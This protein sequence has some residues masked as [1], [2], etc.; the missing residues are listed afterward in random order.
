[1][2][3]REILHVG[4]GST[5]CH[6][7]AHYLNLQ[8]LSVTSSQHPTDE[9]AAEA[10]SCEA[11]ITH[12]TFQRTIVP[13]TLLVD[14]APAIPYRS[15]DNQPTATTSSSSAAI[16]ASK[17]SFLNYSLHPISRN[18]SQ[19]FQSAALWHGSIERLDRTNDVLMAASRVPNRDLLLEAR[20]TAQQLSWAS[21]S[22]YRAP[23][24]SHSSPEYA[25]SSTGRTVDWDSLP[26]EGEEEEEDD[27]EERRRLEQGQERQWKQQVYPPLQQ[28]METIWDQV[29]SSTPST[30][31]GEPGS[32]APNTLND[33]PP[34]STLS[35]QDYWMPPVHPHSTLQLPVRSVESSSFWQSWNHYY[36]MAHA[37]AG[38]DGL[39]PW[40]EDE[41]LNRIRQMLEDCDSCQGFTIAS[42][43]AM[44]GLVTPLLE[45]LQDDCRRA[46]RW[47][48][49][50]NESSIQPDS[51]S[52]SSWRT[53]RV[54]QT[55][56][57]MQV[58]LMWHD[59]LESAHA[60]LELN[61]PGTVD[62]EPHDLFYRSAVLAASMEAATLPLRLSTA[63]SNGT[64]PLS[65]RI[66]LK[67]YYDGDFSGDST[68]GSVS[69]MNLSDF[70]AH[71]Q[72]SSGL[73]VLE[74]DAL[75]SLDHSHVPHDNDEGL[76]S[77]LQEG[78]RF[79]RDQRIK[80]NSGHAGRSQTVLPGRWMMG[81]AHNGGLLTA[82]SPN[83]ES[84]RSRHTH[85]AV[86]SSL[87]YQGLSSS[88]AAL[89]SQY[90]DCLME[91][92]GIRYRPEQSFATHLNQSLS[93]LTNQG[94]GAGAYWKHAWGA[95]PVL[96]VLGNTTR[97]HT[98]AVS[99]G[100]GVKQALSPQSRG[101]LHRDIATGI[102]PEEDNCHEV[103]STIYNLRDRYHPP[104][105]MDDDDGHVFM[106]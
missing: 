101:F 103:L 30:L 94:Y 62:P 69:R 12:T 31:E 32:D 49:S 74:L 61:V 57:A 52:T 8:G 19:Q 3:G 33:I 97:F 88:S 89:S 100:T 106:D 82:L 11:S 24:S 41:Y 65:S 36:P 63:S 39:G 14:A 73:S 18:E 67:S 9:P 5:A 37:T 98:Q 17:E 42:S 28:K 22:R 59:F 84:D 16:E 4:I 76:W 6:V 56:Q 93:S 58:G 83:R 27:E 15:S 48:W 96:S 29:L 35:W 26:P 2:G 81:T 1:M 50:L 78:T 46:R 72:P 86:S 68:F 92:M 105:G 80:Y 104:G 25:V 21:H 90:V 40:M 44:A 64:K 71:L 55:R 54:E 10:P 51:S 91:G 23:V 53:K 99:I 47:V 60:I 77:S 75:V 95:K 13:R 20:E 43:D 79:E 102:L 66:G 38:S 45:Y 85:F 34:R 87:R 7:S 70:L